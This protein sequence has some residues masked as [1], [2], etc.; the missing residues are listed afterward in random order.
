MRMLQ[1]LWSC[2]GGGLNEVYHLWIAGFELWFEAFSSLILCDLW[3]VT[4][5]D[6]VVVQF[7][8]MICAITMKVYPTQR[9][10]I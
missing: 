10:F 3:L 1:I 9:V 8:I 5:Y 7:M 2:F 6:T 4:L